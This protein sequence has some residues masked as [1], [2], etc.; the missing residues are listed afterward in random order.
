M[1]V[2]NGSKH[3]G[4]ALESILNQT[5]QNFE[6]LIIDD[7]SN[8]NSVELIKQ[9]DDSRI[10]LIQNIKNIGQSRTM[11]RGLELAQGEYVARMDQDDISLPERIEKQ[12]IYFENHPKV[13]VLGSHV[14]IVDEELRN[15]VIR[16][17]PMTNY[18]NQWRLLYNTS[19]MHPSV[20]FRRSLFLKYGGY[21]NEYGPAEDYE[22]WSR[23]SQDTEIHQLPDVLAIIR[24]H[25]SSTSNT[26]RLTQKEKAKR[27]RTQNIRRLFSYNEKFNNRCILVKYLSGENEDSNLFW[28]KASVDLF[29]MYFIF[30]SG[31]LM[32]REEINWIS[33]DWIIK[34]SKI[35][36]KYK[37]K[38][39]AKCLNI[40][41]FYYYKYYSPF[42]LLLKNI[43][44]SLKDVTKSKL[45]HFV[46]V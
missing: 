40:N 37:I 46:L 43:I 2:Y 35:P 3:L 33:N 32:T 34:M 45:I 23:L 15:F 7:C 4:G 26:K 17:R 22:Y 30:C 12:V 24:S 27:I 8:D 13:G 20:M 16:S 6:F 44:F 9:Y 42:I 21:N 25:I 31:K 36:I 5:F 29:E 18:E 28:R 14:K 19:V 38:L 41:F 11:N 39:L 10:R 1:P